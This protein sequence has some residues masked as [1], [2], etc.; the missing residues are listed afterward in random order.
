MCGR[1]VPPTEGWDADENHM[2]PPVT[3]HSCIIYLLSPGRGAVTCHVIEACC[4]QPNAG[5]PLSF[6]ELMRPGLMGLHP[7]AIHQHL[8]KHPPEQTV[9]LLCTFKSLCPCRWKRK[10]KKAALLETSVRTFR[11]CPHMVRRDMW[12]S[13]P[14]I[15]SCT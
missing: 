13:Y 12:F 7:Y 14:C 5:K 1:A 8:E 4:Q 2:S 9:S 11:L 10:S 3:A 15:Y 6:P